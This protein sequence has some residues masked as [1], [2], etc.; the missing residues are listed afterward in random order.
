MERVTQMAL[1]V[2]AISVA[3]IWYMRRRINY[4]S[5]YLWKFLQRYPVDHEKVENS[6]NGNIVNNRY[7]EEKDSNRLCQISSMLKLLK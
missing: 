5:N 1:G 7:G 2:D 4:R 6:N 3:C